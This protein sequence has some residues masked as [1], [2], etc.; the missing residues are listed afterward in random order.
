MREIKELSISLGTILTLGKHRLETLSC[1]IVTLV[2]LNTTNLKKLNIGCDNGTKRES[3][4]RRLQRFFSHVTLDY[5]EISSFLVSL[6][7]KPHEQLCVALDRTNWKYGTKHINILML[8]VV[9]MGVAIPVMWTVLGKAG[10]SHTD[11]R[12]KLL[13]R[14]IKVVGPDKIKS[15]LGDREFF[16]KK[17]FEYLQKH[18]I[19]YVIRV[20]SNTI[21]LHR[22]QRIHVSHLFNSLKVGEKKSI[23]N[24]KTIVGL[25]VFLSAVRSLEGK[26]VILATT[27]EALDAVTLYG[28]RWEILFSCLK[29]RGFNFEDTRITASDR[30][31]KM[32]A[33]LAIAF[34]WSHRVGEWCFRNIQPITIKKHGRREKSYFRYGLDVLQDS[35]LS[36]DTFTPNFT[37]F[38]KLLLSPPGVEVKRPVGLYI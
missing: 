8:S 4:Y 30:I 28:R 12:K 3:R 23:K 15:L 26:L 14:F 7:F 11:E 5:N 36:R 17:W 27:E 2:Q 16:G 38:L 25:S 33:V 21:V 34:A 1:L 32:V 24:L 18:G 31:H 37:F 20:K 19:S 29:G 10:N 35:F 6:F 13:D 22:G 9:Y